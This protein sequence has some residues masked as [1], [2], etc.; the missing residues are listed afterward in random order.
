[1]LS[2]LDQFPQVRLQCALNP[3]P[4]NANGQETED[5]QRDEGRIR[6]A[7]GEKVKRRDKHEQKPNRGEQVGV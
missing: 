6:D 5:S 2:F 1:M 7:L 3:N 4:P